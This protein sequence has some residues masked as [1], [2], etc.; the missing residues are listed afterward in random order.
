MVFP[1]IDSCK[2]NIG[3]LK[4]NVK[5]LQLNYWETGNN[6]GSQI[7]A[8]KECNIKLRIPLFF[9]FNTIK[10]LVGEKENLVE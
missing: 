1:E 10:E 7:T 2:T 3:Q 9:I 8:C 4:K 5:W 6:Y